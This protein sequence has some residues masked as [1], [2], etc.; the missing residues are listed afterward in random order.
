MPPAFNLSQDQTLKFNLQFLLALWYKPEHPSK[1]ST[2]T[3]RLF[4]FLKNRCAQQRRGAHYT[5]LSKPV[6]HF[7]RKI[8]KLRCKHLTA[9]EQ[10][11]TNRAHPSHRAEQLRCEERPNYK[12][13][14]ELVKR[15]GE[16]NSQT[17]QSPVMNDAA[18]LQSITICGRVM[19]RRRA[20]AEMFP[21][22]SIAR[23]EQ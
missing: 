11:N 19:P 15:F 21:A 23:F 6:K 14:S 3:Y 8:F 2:H 17:P 7:A 10:P 5:E 16:I 22:R 13:L 9:P 1:P 12:E 20:A 18:A 4:E